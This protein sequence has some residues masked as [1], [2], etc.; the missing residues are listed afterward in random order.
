MP[1]TTVVGIAEN[2]VQN[3]LQATNAYSYYLPLEQFNPSAGA[4]LFLRMNGDPKILHQMAYNGASDSAQW[5][6][7]RNPDGTPI[8]TAPAPG[9]FNLQPGIRNPIH[10][11]GFENWN[12]GLY[13]KFAVNERVGFQFRA[14]AFNAFNHPNWSG[15][16]FTPTSSSFGKVTSKTGDVRNLQLSLRFY[17]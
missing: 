1:C 16:N 7:V 12:I 10:N 4:G 11:P 8:F 6:A 2:M 14:E 13:K 3:D 17:F 15:A 5:F 9:T